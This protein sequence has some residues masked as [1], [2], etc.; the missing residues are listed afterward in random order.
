MRSGLWDAVR[1]STNVFGTI[2]ENQGHKEIKNEMEA[3]MI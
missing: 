2:M 3:G 1:R